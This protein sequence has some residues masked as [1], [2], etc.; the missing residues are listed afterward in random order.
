M[1]SEAILRLKFEHF[2]TVLDDI[3]IRTNANAY[4]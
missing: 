3:R 1:K 4:R 2:A